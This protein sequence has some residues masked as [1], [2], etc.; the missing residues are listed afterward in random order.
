MRVAVAIEFSNGWDSPVSFR[1][2]RAPFFAI[3]D[4]SRTPPAL[5]IIPNPHINTPRGVGP[6]V[7]QWLVNQG[8]NVVIASRIGPNAMM[9]L[10]LSLI[11]I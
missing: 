2:G 7:V 10:Q 6:L 9:V 5:Q 3:V 11:H 8:V 1:F 4:L